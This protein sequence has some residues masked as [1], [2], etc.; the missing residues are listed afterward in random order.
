MKL[1]SLYIENFGRLNRFSL[2]CSEGINTVCEENGWGKSTLAAFIKAMFYGLPKSGKKNLDENE[3]RKYAPWQ[4]GIYGGNLVFECTHGKFRVERTFGDPETFTLFDLSTGLPSNAFGESLGQ[5][6]F[7]IDADGFERSTYLSAR[8]LDPAGKNDTIRAKLTGVLDDVNDMN[9]FESACSAL[10][11]RA[12]EYKKTG[13]RGKIGELDAEIRSLNEKLRTKRTLLSEQTE[14]EKQLAGIRRELNEVNAEAEQIRAQSALAALIEEK[15]RREEDIR[16][17]EADRD[18][19]PKAFDGAIPSAEEL[20]AQ[21]RLLAQITGENAEL[22][23]IGLDPDE[24]Q[25]LVHL[26]NLFPTGTPS[27]EVLEEQNRLAAALR[28]E[29]SRHAA[30]RDLADRALAEANARL[31]ALPTAAELQT[32]SDLLTA[33]QSSRASKPSVIRPKILLVLALL[34]SAIGA[35]F[36]IFGVL[37]SALPFMIGGG[38][39]LIAGLSCLLFGRFSGASDRAERE[40]TGEQTNQTVRSLLERYGKSADGDPRRALNDLS[41]TLARAQQSVADAQSRA[42]ALQERA[43]ALRSREAD[44]RAFLSG[45]H[46][47]D[48]DPENGLRHLSD[49][50]RDWNRLT[51]KQRDSEYTY[52]KKHASIQLLTAE[53]ERF[54]SRC[55]MLSPSLDA[56]QRLRTV[57]GLLSRHTLLVEEIARQK[58]NL[59]SFIVEKGLDTLPPEAAVNFASLN[60]RSEQ[61]KARRTA[62][63][64]REH[65]LSLSLDRISRETEQIPELEESIARLKEEQA[66]AAERFRLLTLTRNYLIDAH[67]ALTTRYL[68]GTRKSFSKYLTLLAGADAPAADVNAQFGVSVM[69]G[70][71]T[72]QPE[73]YSRGW[74]D[75][76]QFCV[77]LSLVDA[78]FADGEKPFLLLDDPFTNLD[79]KRLAF[80][81]ELLARLASEFQVLYLTCHSDRI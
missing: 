57:E 56:D 47:T 5:E 79:E 74:R 6:L 23:R 49:L 77:R 30:E 16:R 37:R 43:Y 13:G 18:E 53:S 11:N 20:D 73:A 19:I 80:A 27:A 65:T 75:I 51:R 14:S 78:L 70:G 72:R 66:D 45:Y 67:D 31:C 15:R 33:S 44:L 8:A 69:D 71:M 61:I 2:N 10:E 62:L 34:L 46:V 58:R 60:A 40:Q 22:R 9:N 36:L 24:Q 41:E 29:K 25:E 12:K 4:G 64:E 68:D 32:A 1:I 28:D 63:S 17:L 76:L 7:G 42:A 35:G 38:A 39:A 48:P 54:F 81:K 52:A 50:C 26:S 3:Q 55:K 21:R 59:Q